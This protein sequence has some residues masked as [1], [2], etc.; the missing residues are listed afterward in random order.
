M[1]ISTL[2]HGDDDDDKV[3]ETNPHPIDENSAKKEAVE[4]TNNQHNTEHN[5]NDDD[6]D[7]NTAPPQSH[8]T[9]P[10][11][12]PKQTQDQTSD[13][14][15]REKIE[16]IPE[17]IRIMKKHRLQSSRLEALS[18]TSTSTPG[19]SQEQQTKN[20]LPLRRGSSQQEA[21]VK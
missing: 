13:Q 20:R 2:L 19:T 16:Q 8:P 14:N 12:P 18:S 5:D 11:N 4:S 1:V 3:S 9:N 17:R 10:N 15:Q 21:V 7:D 6:D